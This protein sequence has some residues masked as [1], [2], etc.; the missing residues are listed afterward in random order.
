MFGLPII[1]AAFALNGAPSSLPVQCN[2]AT[3][4]KGAAAQTFFVPGTTT[5]LRSD[6]GATVCVG[7]LW[8]AASAPERMAILAL[9]PSWTLARFEH[10]AGVA[11]IVVLHESRHGGGDRSES[12]A[13][14]VALRELDAFAAQW[15]PADDLPVIVAFGKA[16]DA[17]LPADYHG[18]C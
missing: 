10:A 14:C 9:N 2:P 4:A 12:H 8:L 5:A 18:G 13:E 1:L 6:F 3:E 15:A 17:G 7:L 11:L 16:Y